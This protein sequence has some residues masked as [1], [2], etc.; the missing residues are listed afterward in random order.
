M[1]E[2]GETTQIFK[3]ALSQ[4]ERMGRIKA[5]NVWSMIDMYATVVQPVARMVGSLPSTQVSV[6]RLFF[7]KIVPTWM[8]MDAILF[9][10]TNKYVRTFRT[11]R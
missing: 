5:E 3:Q 1:A 6:E 8:L 2:T 11:M 4:V 10:R 7:V 9:L